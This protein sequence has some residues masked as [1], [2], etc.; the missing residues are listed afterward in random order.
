MTTTALVSAARLT[1]ATRGAE[2]SYRPHQRQMSAQSIAG[3]AWGLHPGQAL[4]VD[5]AQDR[6]GQTPRAG[7][8]RKA[9][10]LLPRHAERHLRGCATLAAPRLFH[11]VRFSDCRPSALNTL[12]HEQTVNSI[13]QVPHLSIALS[14][15]ASSAGSKYPATRGQK[16]G[17]AGQLREA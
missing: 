14:N 11:S 2:T 6:P 4:A 1:T 16:I 10:I 8:I 5:Y 12:A 13:A 7:F 15:S 9:A 3:A 17:N